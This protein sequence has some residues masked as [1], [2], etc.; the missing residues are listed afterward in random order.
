L[1]RRPSRGRSSREPSY[2]RPRPLAAA[3]DRRVPQPVHR[4]EKFTR[5]RRHS[6]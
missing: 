3:T 5:P 2:L 4:A 6:V 1:P